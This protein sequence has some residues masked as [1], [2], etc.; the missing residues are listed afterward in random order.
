MDYRKLS[1]EFHERGFLIREDFFA[2]EKVAEIEAALGQYIAR[3]DE[4]SEAYVVY[5]PGPERKIRNIFEM[6]KFDPYFAQ[7]ALEPHLIELVKAIFN[8]EPISMGVE[9]FGKPARVGSEVPYHQDNAYFNLEPDQAL[10]V[11]IALADATEA[12]GCVRYI[13]G[14]HKLGNLPHEPS[15]V[16]GN[17]QRLKE[18]PQG[19]GPEVSG[20]V[21]RGGVLI[22]HCN[23]IHRSEPNRSDHDRPGLL[24]VYKATRCQI[25]RGR[26]ENYN[27]TLAATA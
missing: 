18:L 17:S 11:W 22:H 3:I 9:L 20:I 25:D 5:E 27:A 10:T 19:A 21:K 16:K 8:D 13:E 4:A 24:L 23:N 2:P 26:V 14:S 1:D 7:M 15:G 12:N 6:E